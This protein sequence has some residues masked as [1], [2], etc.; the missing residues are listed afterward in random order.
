MS[1]PGTQIEA[2]FEGS[3]PAA[4]YAEAGGFR[5]G[6]GLGGGKRVGS[7]RATGPDWTAAGID[8]AV[9]VQKMWDQSPIFRVSDSEPRLAEALSAR[10]FRDHTPT[11]M[12]TAP[13]AALTD[14][15]VP[16]VTS[17]ALWPPLAIQ[18]ELWEEQGIGPARQAVMARVAAPKAALLGRIKD[19]AA[20]VAF[21]AEVQGIAVLH[22]LE[23]LPSM[24]R[25][26]LATWTLREA[27]FWAEAR[28]ADTMLLA[29]TAGN[30]G[31]I[32]LYRKLGFAPVAGYRYFEA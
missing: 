28:G 5:I 30:A 3:W 22:A 24:R 11:V 25:E 16:P 1:R 2:A 23:V 4:E 14:I 9:D 19:R 8:R 15:D 21:V 26:G 13:V 10:G 17:F 32:A 6:R 18:R 7:A 29:V 12:M 27:A 20:A 31:A